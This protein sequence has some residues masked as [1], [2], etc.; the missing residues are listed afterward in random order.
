[1]QRVMA[2]IPKKFHVKVATL[3][4]YLK[5]H[6]NLIRVT[7]TGRP[8]VAGKEIMRAHIMD[9]M[10]SL[11]L[12]PKSQALPSG[13]K[14]V[15][16]ALHAIGAP[17]HLL[18][19]LAVRT[20]YHSL[21]GAA[22]QPH[23]ETEEQEPE[24]E[25]EEQ[26]LETTPFEISLHSSIPPLPAVPKVEERTPIIPKLERKAEE[27]ALSKP[28]S[29]LVPKPER[30]GS[31]TMQT[32]HAASKASS[33]GIP[34]MSTKHELIKT[35]GSQT[36]KGRGVLLSIGIMMCA[37]REGGFVYCVYQASAFRRCR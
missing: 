32:R 25:E 18:S 20:M 3:G 13:V 34:A 28:N 15:I 8:I 30:A 23:A 26:E 9:I 11:Y 27:R 16:E 10:R 21:H 33:S 4:Y 2:E 5:A 29:S 14:E 35:S 12:W 36:G 19:N 1:M 24:G 7:P 31:V 22:E 17:S 37:S 6:P